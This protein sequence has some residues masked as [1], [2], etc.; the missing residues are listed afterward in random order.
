MIERIKQLL[1][2]IEKTQVLSVIFH[3]Q[4]SIEYA[5]MVELADTLDLGAVTSVKIYTSLILH[6]DIR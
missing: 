4:F 1:T 5:G 3:S 6:I 2:A